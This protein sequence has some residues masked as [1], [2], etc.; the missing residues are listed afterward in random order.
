[1]TEKTSSAT[2]SAKEARV[3]TRSGDG[4]AGRP[5]TRD[6]FDRLAAMVEDLDR[7]VRQNRKDLD[8]QFQRLAEL[9]AVIDRIQIAAKR[10]RAGSDGHG[11]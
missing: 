10:A 8:V 7:R 2:E 6:E 1:M 11:S 3:R 4:H 5:P 9:Q